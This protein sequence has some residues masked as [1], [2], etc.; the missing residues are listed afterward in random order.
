VKSKYKGTEGLGA[1][2]GFKVKEQ[3]N[4]KKYWNMEK[5]EEF[6]QSREFQ[7]L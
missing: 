3:V 1:E 7:S 5:I 2:A 6:V 4:R